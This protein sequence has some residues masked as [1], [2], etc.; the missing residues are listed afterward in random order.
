MKAMNHGLLVSL[1]LGA[2]GCGNPLKMQLKRPK[3]PELGVLRWLILIIL[4]NKMFSLQA[5]S[6][7]KGHPKFFAHTDD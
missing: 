6:N 7:K 1:F 5:L 4:K 3:Q 2:G